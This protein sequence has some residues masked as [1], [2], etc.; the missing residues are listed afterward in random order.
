MKI[1]TA[2]FLTCAV[3]TCKT[4]QDSYPLHFRDAELEQSDIQYNPSFI[5]NILPRLD[6][7]AFKITATE[8]WINSI[9]YVPISPFSLLFYIVLVKMPGDSSIVQKC[10]NELNPVAIFTISLLH[11]I[12][13]SMQNSPLI[14][15]F[16]V[17]ELKFSGLHSYS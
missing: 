2:N 9:S 7:E 8:V 10:I 1:L 13:T 14:F 11:S 16:L 12:V 6:W 15:C 5:K 3:K 4:S 17:S